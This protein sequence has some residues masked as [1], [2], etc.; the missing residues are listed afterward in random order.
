MSL[1]IAKNLAID[2][3]RRHRADPTE[4]AELAEDAARY[5]RP[6]VPDPFLRSIVL[7]CRDKL[8]DK[9]KLALGERLSNEG[10]EPDRVLAKRLKMDLN[11]FLQNVTRARRM[12][13]EC[14]HKQ[15]VDLAQELP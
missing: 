10:A 13:A 5:D 2:L 12:M 6:I 9:P 3:A 1:R 11:T 4:L 15:G 7:G 8:P 14:L